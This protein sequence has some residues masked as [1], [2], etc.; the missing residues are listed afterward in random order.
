MAHVKFK[1]L[2]LNSIPEDD[3]EEIKRETESIPSD[4][5]FATDWLERTCRNELG[6][7]DEQIKNRPRSAAEL[8]YESYL[9]SNTHKI[10]WFGLHVIMV[11]CYYVSCTSFSKVM[12]LLIAAG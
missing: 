7:T 6:I 5:E 3:V 10:T 2:R 8:G 4:V 1:A 9:H 11:P 12:V